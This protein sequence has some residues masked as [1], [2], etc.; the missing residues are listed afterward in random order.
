MMTARDIIA[1]LRQG[2]SPTRDELTWFAQG[3][4]DGQVSDAQAGA[5][6][7]AVC[8]NGINDEGR[9]ALTMAMR[10]SGQVIDWNVDQPVLDKHS[11][12]GVGD[13]AGAVG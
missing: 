9:V 10:D 5:F 12:G 6:A 1:K 7:M 13:C 11:T 3:L 8:L 4:A 2:Q